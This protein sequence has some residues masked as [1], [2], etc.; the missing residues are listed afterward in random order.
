MGVL[1]NLKDAAEVLRQND[2]TDLYNKISEAEDEVRD[3]LR[4]KRRLEDMVE[5]LDRALRFREEAVFRAPFYYLKI[6]D[7]TPYCAR[8]WEKDKHAVHVVL[9]PDILER[10]ECPECNRTYVPCSPTFLPRGE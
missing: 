9:R 6:G 7:Q 8:C 1:D 3:L 10:W 4:E 5:E 2:Q